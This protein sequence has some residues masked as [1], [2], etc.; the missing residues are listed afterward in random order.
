MEVKW[1]FKFEIIINVLSSSFRFIWI[2]MLDVYGHYHFFQCGDRIYTNKSD[3][4]YK[5]GPRAEER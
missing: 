3:V 5:D 4:K 1:F 2:P